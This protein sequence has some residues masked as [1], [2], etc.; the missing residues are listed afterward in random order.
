MAII[1]EQE[2]TDLKVDVGVLK[3][4]V[5]TLSQLCGKMDKVI[6]RLVDV[7]DQHISKVYET[8]DNQRKEKDD[9]IAEVHERID[10][11]LEKLTGTEKRIMDEFQSL[12]KSMS[13]HSANTKAQFEKINQWKWTLAGGIIVITWLISRVGFDTLLKVL[14]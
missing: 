10:V 4:Q 3:T 2:Y 8:M 5:F 1:P 14:H 13:E 7:H 11:V 12:K 6:E 9:D